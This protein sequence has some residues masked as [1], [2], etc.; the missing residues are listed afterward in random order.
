VSGTHLGLAT[1]FSSFFNRFLAVT[2]LF[3]W[4]A[5]SDETWGLEFSVFAEHRQYSL[6][7]EHI[8]VSLFLGLP[9]LGGPGSYIYLPQEQLHPRALG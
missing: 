5:L 6:S 1:N 8:L 4:E 2:D 7:H 9:N 3:L